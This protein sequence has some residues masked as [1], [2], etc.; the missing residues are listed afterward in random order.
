M[1]TRVYLIQGV[2]FALGLGLYRRALGLGLG[3]TMGTRVY[4]IQGVR[5]R[6][7]AV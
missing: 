2:G 1:G 7:K 5:V 6:V 4:L 3:E